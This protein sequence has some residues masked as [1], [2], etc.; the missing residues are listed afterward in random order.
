LGFMEGWKESFEK[1][2]LPSSWGSPKADL[3]RIEK[4]IDEKMANVIAPREFPDLGFWYYNRHD[5]DHI[6]RVIGYLYEILKT[7]K[8]KL[9]PHE[10]YFL[11][12]AAYG[13]DLGM[14]IWNDSLKEAY[15]RALG[16]KM[17]T[18][19]MRKTHGV[20]SGNIIEDIL[21]P[22]IKNPEALG[23]IREIVSYHCGEIENIEDLT[24]ERIIDGK[25]IRIG[26]LIALLRIADTMD[27]G[28]Q[29][30]PDEEI[31][32]TS[33]AL[34]STCEPFQGQF[35]HYMRRKIIESCHYE[36]EGIVLRVRRRF[37]NFE[38]KSPA[39]KKGKSICVTGKD[40]FLGVL[41]EF[42][43]ELGSPENLD[44]LEKEFPDL[45]WDKLE[46]V[47]KKQTSNRLLEKYK[48]KIPWIVDFFGHPD[49]VISVE[50]ELKAKEKRKSYD[51]EKPHPIEELLVK[52]G[53]IEPLIESLMRIEEALAAQDI[54]PNSFRPGRLFWPDMERLSRRD[55][56]DK[57]IKRFDE[58]NVVLM[59]GYPA[60][61]KSSIACRLGYE[62]V[63][64][65]KWV[66]YGN[67][68][69]RVGLN[70]QPK[71]LPG[72]IFEEVKEIKQEV[73]IIIEDIHHLVKEF[74][75]LNFIT[76]HKHIKLLL[77]SRPLKQYDVKE[78]FGHHEGRS[79]YFQW[80]VPE[81]KIELKTDKDVVEKIL[82]EAESSFKLD[83]IL[84][85]I[86]EDQPNL[87]LLSFLIQAS[88]K[89]GKQAD[90]IKEEI[91]KLVI[92]HLDRLKKSTC[93]TSQ[94]QEAFRKVIG[95][96]SVLSEFEVPME[97]EFIDGGAVDSLLE[98]LEKKK[99]IL[100]LKG[101]IFGQEYYLI[102]HSR[103]AS[104]YRNVCLDEEE[105]RE[106]LKDYIIQGDFFGTLIGR[107]VSEAGRLL[108]S[109]IKESRKEL[110]KRDLSQASIEEIGNFLEVI[111][112]NYAVHK[113]YT[114]SG[115]LVRY[116]YIL[117][118]DKE[119]A[120]EI[121]RANRNTLRQKDISQADIREIGYFLECIAE[122]DKELAKEIV[123]LHSDTLKQ[124]DLSQASIREIGLFLGYIAWADKELAKEIVRLHTDTLKLKLYLASIKEIRAFL[125]KIIWA[126]KE[127]TREIVRV[128]SDILK[129]KL[130]QASIREIKAFFRKIAWADK[131]LAKEIVRMSGKNTKKETV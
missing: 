101:R 85:T 61:G 131:E 117:W 72:R 56:I 64:E 28:E 80:I 49:D 58:D 78:Y 16:R 37:C 130:S 11:Y 66:Y 24:K 90:E 45:A 115:H 34:S 30:L 4:E 54:E 40:A 51:E 84:K 65:S 103:L 27:A 89:K 25:K 44:E 123:R 36:K 93:K 71:E 67:L 33:L 119:L 86:G 55:E 125:K 2:N 60:S 5:I 121:A 43:K 83:H 53:L 87:L 96:L 70:C 46:D 57:I 105:R 102:S 32:A 113:E 15:E 17:D 112:Q 126:D 22:Y 12:L 74:D 35:E 9:R 19:L 52:W 82:R 47:W 29:R 98:R 95:T 118:A 100:S 63:K 110:I 120:R 81:N 18:F 6:K 20:A 107:L 73:F 59:E 108:K 94:D 69:T 99:E 41:E 23:V 39:G 122:V 114:D 97:R 76:D 48:L 127:L 91:R 128:H 31:I 14:T 13:H 1:F 77:T 109:L 21:K 88:K 116:E 3:W 42:G 106:V 62:L 68:T 124:K 8:I 92:D 129:Q 50:W 38:V 7:R 111:A 75:N 26:L 104:L 10:Q 79:L